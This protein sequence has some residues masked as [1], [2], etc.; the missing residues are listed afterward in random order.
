MSQQAVTPQSQ[1]FSAWYNDVVY[2]ADLVSPS[3]VRGCLIIKPYGYEIWEGIRA[4]LDKRFKA[5]GHQNAYF[6]LFIP[7]SYLKREA[8]HVEGFSPELAVV[9]IAGGKELEEP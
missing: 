7:E 4:G 2:K 6:P 8:E 3:P 1:D 5:T 9:T